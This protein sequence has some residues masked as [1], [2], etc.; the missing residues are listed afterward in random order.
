[1]DNELFIVE[2]HQK[3]SKFRNTL[4]KNCEKTKQPFIKHFL[5]NYIN[6]YQEPY[7]KLPPFWNIGE[8]TTFGDILLLLESLDL[9]KFIVN[10]NCQ[11]NKVAKKLGAQNI[12]TLNSWLFTIKDI[13]NK[14]AHHSRLWNSITPLPKSVSNFILNEPSQKNRLYQ[15][16]VILQV[17]INKLDIQISVKDYVEDLIAQFPIAE[18]F[19]IDCGFPTTWKNEDIW[20]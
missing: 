17:M 2:K 14:C 10:S 6:R 9:N 19:L 15:A 20:K 16:L 4:I 11:L 18:Q 1:M 5:E 13:R 7:N 8:L 3:I 12:K